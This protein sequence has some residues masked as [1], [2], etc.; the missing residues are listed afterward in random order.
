MKG[1]A[2]ALSGATDETLMT[3]YA[4]GDADAFDMLYDR[5]KGAVFRYFTR[6]LTES[7]AHDCFQTLWLNIIRH[8]SRYEPSAAFRHY[9]FTV[10][11]NVLMDH[12]RKSIRSVSVDVDPDTEPAHGGRPDADHEREEV[13]ARLHAE[14][15]ALPAPQREVWLLRQESDLSLKEIAEVTGVAEEA[16]KSRLRYAR[17]KLRQGMSRYAHRN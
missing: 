10:A 6:Q 12:H 3:A 14:V 5:H 11:H 17:D 2:P 4:A 16:A 1:A 15:R 8:R 7:D 9:L 13:L